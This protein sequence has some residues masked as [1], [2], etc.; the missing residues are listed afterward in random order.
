MSFVV[1]KELL[2]GYK[3]ALSRQFDGAMKAAVPAQWQQITTVVNTGTKRVDFPWLGEAGSMRK[4]VGPRIE[5]QLK[6][7]KYSIEVE[8][9]ELTMGIDRNDLEDDAGGM[10][11]QYESQVPLKLADPALRHPAELIFEQTLPNGHL[12]A[13]YDGQNFFDT[14][15]PVGDET[16]TSVSNLYV[17]S[18]PGTGV[19]WYVMDVS[20][21]QKPMV[22]TLRKAPEF[23]EQFDLSSDRVFYDR[24]FV[25]GVDCRDAAGF[26]LWQQAA[27]ST[28]ALTADNLM[29]VALAMAA[30][31]NDEGQKMGIKGNLLVVP[32]SLEYVADKILTLPLINGGETNPLYNKFKLL[33]S[34]QLPDA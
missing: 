27:R 13:C 19:P 9:Y 31:K 21:A 12:I 7:Y 32:S 23:Q 5:K 26:G 16:I 30:I 28:E 1:N 24:K 17:G 20:R 4:W 8:D 22:Y 3:V 10:L 2:D 34:S 15:H 33:V 18:G 14:D 6:A 25:F 29:K 11:P